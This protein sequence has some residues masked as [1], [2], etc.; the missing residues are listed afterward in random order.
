MYAHI[1]TGQCGGTE[2]EALNTGSKRRNELPTNRLHLPSPSLL[3]AVPFI[4]FFHLAWENDRSLLARRDYLVAALCPLP[5]PFKCP[6]SFPC[7]PVS[8]LYQ[9]SS[10]PPSPPPRTSPLEASPS[11]LWGLARSLLICLPTRTISLRVSR[12]SLPRRSG[13]RDTKHEAIYF[14]A[15]RYSRIARALC[16]PSLPP[17]SWSSW[18]FLLP[19]SVDSLR[20]SFHLTSSLRTVS[21]SSPPT[22]IFSPEVNLVFIV[23]VSRRTSS[24]EANGYRDVLITRLCRPPGFPSP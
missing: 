22:A 14:L 9:A 23:L 5:S 6:L 10:S 18:P 16:W 21:P 15:S 19:P 3:R 12:V 2:A 20:P 17:V 8:P 24:S 4:L 1:R 11:R 7:P 13:M